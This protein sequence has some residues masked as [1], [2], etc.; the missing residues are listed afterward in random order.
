MGGS[1]GVSLHRAVTADYIFKDCANSYRQ[2]FY[3]CRED[4]SYNIVL[5]SGPPPLNC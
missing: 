3:F 2:R 5:I 1:C 4:A